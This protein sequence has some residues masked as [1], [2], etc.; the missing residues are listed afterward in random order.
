MIELKDVTYGYTDKEVL[1]NV[2]VRFDTGGMYA[3]MG[4]NGCG[5]TTLLRLVAGLLS[6]HSGE[7]TV[8]GKSVKQYSAIQ[9]ARRM[10]Y[11][12]QYPQTDF[13]FSAFE[14]VLM[15]RNPY[16]RRL[17]NESQRDWDIV[18]QCMKQTNTWHLRL[19]K[20]NQMSGGELQ[21]VMLARAL[22][23]QTP[24]MLLDE[25]VSNLDI[26]HQFEILELLRTVNREEQALRAAI[27]DYLVREVG[28]H[29]LK[30]ELCVPTMIM[31]H[32][33]E[34]LV[35]GDFW[36]LW[37]NVAGDTLKCVSGGNHAGAMTIGRDGGRYKVTGFEQTVDGAGNVA[38][39]KRIFGGYY[40]IYENIHSSEQVRE[41]VRQEQ[42]REYVKRNKLAVSY[43]QDYGWPAV[44]L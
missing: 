24:V 29:Y 17:Q 6:P 36:V 42:L 10:A 20:P 33:E 23:Q 15:G 3:I 38:S 19:A 25:P 40:D 4:A 1:H 16:Q 32:E 21:R 2:S 7:V 14:T 9:L 8:E 39:A 43:Y 28:E 11:V 44:K 31:V 41:A 13:E 5:K 37:Y 22:A 12:R 26:A 30:G 27:G 35:M 34:G 18:E